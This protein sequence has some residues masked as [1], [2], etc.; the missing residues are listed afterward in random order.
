M[1][2]PPRRAMEGAVRKSTHFLDTQ[3][4]I[5]SSQHPEHGSTLLMLFR[6]GACSL[7]SAWRWCRS[8]RPQRL[9]S[10][11][12]ARAS[13][14][15]SFGARATSTSSSS[16]PCGTTPPSTCGRPTSGGRAAATRCTRAPATRSTSAATWDKPLPQQE[17]PR[18]VAP[19]GRPYRRRGAGVPLVL[20]ETSG[21]PASAARPSC[22]AFRRR[23]GGG[24][25]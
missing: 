5:G 7:L 3:P 20:R 14:G 8:R 2:L 10:A 13:G 19:E 25:G 21:G 22:R 9:T 11:R 4:H 16:S 17:V 12:A 18:E 15:R 24:P 6:T 1:F 23:R